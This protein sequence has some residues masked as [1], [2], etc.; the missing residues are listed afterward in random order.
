MKKTYQS[1]QVT[2]IQLRAEQKTVRL[3][4]MPLKATQTPGVIGCNLIKSC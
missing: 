2:I 3:L 1:Q 4:L